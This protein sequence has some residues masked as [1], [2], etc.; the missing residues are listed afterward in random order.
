MATGEFEKLSQADDE[1]EHSIEL[2]LPYIA[3]VMERCEHQANY[4]T[5]LIASFVQSLR[6][7]IRVVILHSG[8]NVICFNL[9]S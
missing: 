2:H 9:A 3:K 4:Y 6:P 1:R 7:I 8:C 5:L